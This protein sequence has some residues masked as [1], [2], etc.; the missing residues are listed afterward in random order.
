VE[1]LSL[2]LS[3]FLCMV[4]AGSH[5]QLA[6]GLVGDITGSQECVHGRRLQTQAGCPGLGW[7]AVMPVLL[8]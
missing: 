6:P 3:F 8:K 7:L 5:A 1:A 4:E 2:S